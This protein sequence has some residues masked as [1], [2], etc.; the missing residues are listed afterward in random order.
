MKQAATAPVHSD[1][2]AREPSGRWKATGGFV[3]RALAI[4]VF[5]ASAGYA[6][7][8]AAQSPN[9][10][11]ESWIR[12]QVERSNAGFVAPDPAIVKVLLLAP[13]A[14]RECSGAV[15]SPNRVVTAAN[16][17]VD[18]Q[19]RWPPGRVIVVPGL[20]GWRRE[21]WGSFEVS[22]AAHDGFD[23]RRTTTSSSSGAIRGRR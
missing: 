5:M 6:A 22:S 21:R 3:L 4:A 9:A 7:E 11:D 23:P 20:D 8:H 18:D 2:T 19:G 14:V 13:D 12:R 16:C 1:M 17:L 15:I 10:G